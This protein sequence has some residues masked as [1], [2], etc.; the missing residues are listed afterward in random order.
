MRELI[1]VTR[2]RNRA[3][4]GYEGP[5]I[6]SVISEAMTKQGLDRYQV[7]E[8]AG[9][10]VS[11]I[12]GL[13]SGRSAGWP[14]TI[15]KVEKAL[16]VKLAGLPQIPEPVSLATT[17]SRNAHTIVGSKGAAPKRPVGRPRVRFFSDPDLEA[18]YQERR[19]ARKRAY[20]KRRKDYAG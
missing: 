17:P 4:Q 15:K 2:Y 11:L 1:A 12:Y 14:R 7:A 10:A 18:R 8:K 16:S 3:P 19:E 13:V 5:T 6:A 9:L 20:E